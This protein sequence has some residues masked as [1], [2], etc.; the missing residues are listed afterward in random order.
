MATSTLGDAGKTLL[1]F[2]HVLLLVMGEAFPGNHFVPEHEVLFYEGHSPHQPC[3]K[4]A[5]D[6]MTMRIQDS[7][8]E[9]RV[10]S[11]EFNLIHMTSP[12][13][14]RLIVGQSS[15]TTNTRE[16][17]TINSSDLNVLN[18]VSP[19]FEKIFSNFQ[20]VEESTL[21]E[22]ALDLRRENCGQQ[23]GKSVEQQHEVYT[24]TFVDALHKMHE[25]Q[26]NHRENGNR[27]KLE[28]NQRDMR[29][30][31]DEKQSSRLFFEH[32]PEFLKLHA[33]VR[34]SET[35]HMES[36]GREFRHSEE[37]GE[38]ELAMASPQFS[39][40]PIDLQVQ[41]IVK[42]E[43][44][45]QK[46]RV[47]ASKCRKK[48]LAREAQLEVTVQQLKE[49]NIELNAVAN[50]LRNQLTDLKQKVMEHIACGCHVTLT[51][52]Y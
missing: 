15:L 27:N 13:L 12:D 34:L 14:E 7:L 8:K 22:A 9:T 4:I 47:A 21:R 10:T 11:P 42:R 45:K 18:L 46:N 43:R 44:K 2:V 35:A 36:R 20:A 30:T 51:M 25:Q 5:R 49:R 3:H 41:E 37:L 31:G 48:K 19:D 26:L 33:H 17:T 32:H 16:T 29:E 39:L 28:I 52:T 23:L 40:H 6:R 50:A 24:K 1:Y 38:Q